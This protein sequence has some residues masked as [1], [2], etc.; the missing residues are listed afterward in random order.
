MVD[1]RSVEVTSEE[2]LIS[3]D[4]SA[5]QPVCRAT[6]VRAGRAERLLLAGA[7]LAALVLLVLPLYQ[8]TLRHSVL[9]NEGWNAFHA[10]R[11][12]A[13]L[14]LYPGVD[15]L[16]V[17]NYP[18]LS[19]VVL[20]PLGQWLGDQ[21]LAGRVLTLLSMLL[22]ALLMAR[23]I[24]VRTGAGLVGW[25]MVAYVL[26][27]E[28]SKHVIRFGVNDPQWLGHLLM[29]AGLCLL[30]T[31]GSVR[32]ARSAG[33]V[34]AAALLVLAGGLV[35]HS[36]L[37]VPLAVPLW[38]AIYD[39]RALILWLI[40]GGLFGLLSLAVAELV[41]PCF[42]ASVL[43]IETGRGMDMARLPGILLPQL[44]H[45]VPALA[46]AVWGFW[47]YRRADIAFTLI[48]AAVALLVGAFFLAG[49]GVSDNVLYDINIAA[50]LGAG[51]A[52]GAA[53]ADHP[54][55]R[56][57]AARV[58]PL[59][60][61]ALL[62]VI[63]WPALEIVRDWPEPWHRLERET[64]ASALDIATVARVPGA[65][66]CETPSL[67]YWAGKP[68][69][70]DMFNIGERLR[71]GSI[72]AESVVA[73]LR[74]HRVQLVQLERAAGPGRDAYER[75]WGGLPPALL[76]RWLE[77]YIVVETRGNG[78]VFMR[79]A[80]AGEGVAEPTADSPAPGGARP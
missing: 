34:L 40:G 55:D 48:Y 61:A 22:T 31:G 27:F 49:S 66:V 43:G 74:D 72:D 15:E 35:K 71:A 4:L 53:A 63:A 16:I 42:L 68:F 70:L 38:L 78:R 19:F 36:L 73:R 10:I 60:M 50:T 17:N 3:I 62:V 30:L 69:L 5:E 11:L 67:C 57:G 6:M 52:L 20:A 44:A 51:L 45:L 37:A 65:A 24:R 14:P 32:D 54:A 41:F 75:L 25:F 12:A 39:R 7:I 80:S 76:D 33:R 21:V 58:V 29:T 46:I 13:G 18:P 79:P 9:P 56:V 77:G 23:L 1:D 26:G 47:R 59:G 28:A 2:K 64:E 8:T